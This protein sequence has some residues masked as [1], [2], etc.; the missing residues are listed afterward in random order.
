MYMYMYIHIYKHIA[1]TYINTL[2]LIR[3]LAYNY[4]NVFQSLGN[5]VIHKELQEGMNGIDIVCKT[6]LIL[7]RD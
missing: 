4:Y 7:H 5:R 6:D 2:A 1:L 3:L